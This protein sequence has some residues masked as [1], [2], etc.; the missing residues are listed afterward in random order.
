MLLSSQECFLLVKK[1]PQEH[2]VQ[3]SCSV[4]STRA[5]THYIVLQAAHGPAVTEIHSIAG[6]LV[7]PAPPPIACPQKPPAGQWQHTPCEP[8]REARTRVC[9]MA[10]QPAGDG[11]MRRR[12][13]VVGRRRARAAAW[14]RRANAG[15]IFHLSCWH[16]R[17]RASSPA[18]PRAA[19]AL[20]A[21][22]IAAASSEAGR[23]LAPLI[24]LR[25]ARTLSCLS[26]WTPL[27][28]SVHSVCSSAPH[29]RLPILQCSVCA[30]WCRVFPCLARPRRREMT[31]LELSSLRQPVPPFCARAS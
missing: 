1:R 19:C 5:C 24:S 28:L 16:V 17:R 9:G 7:A 20:L 11:R 10:C 3:C 18:R 2:P 14:Q 4:A 31:P 8:G 26:S 15:R 29:C 22:L 30:P 25:P 21:L 12:D 23:R 6:Q 13:L 27:V